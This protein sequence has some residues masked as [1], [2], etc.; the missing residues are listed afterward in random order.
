M[1]LFGREIK[2]SIGMR[3]ERRKAERVP[4]H[5]TLYLDYQNSFRQIHGSGEGKNLSLAG[6]LFAT[7]SPVPV[8]SFLEL[9]LHL[10]P[11]FATSAPIRLQSRVVRSFQTSTQEHYRIACA[12][13][14]L[15][16]HLTSTIESFIEWLKDRNRT[17]FYR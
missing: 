11:A 14:P 16:K 8:G 7:S 4:L 15:E 13:D 3:R 1:K 5:E 17:D 12:F 2:L 9:V 10:Y 6:I